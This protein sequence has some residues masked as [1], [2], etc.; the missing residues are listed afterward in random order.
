[1]TFGRN[2]QKTLDRIDIPQ[3]PNRYPI[4]NNQYRYRDVGIPFLPNTDYWM[5]QI[6]FVQRLHLRECNQ[7]SIIK[8]EKWGKMSFH[9]SDLLQ[10]NWIKLNF[11]NSGKFPPR[12]KKFPG[13]WPCN[14]DRNMHA[15]CR[16]GF[17]CSGSCWHISGFL[18]CVYW[19]LGAHFHVTKMLNYE[20]KQNTL[21]RIPKSDFRAPLAFIRKSRGKVN[22]WVFP[23]LFH[24]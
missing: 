17:N 2:I 24:F 15:D 7:N 8:F 16:G 13:R 18:L 9:D 4:F 6:Q 20:H 14:R 19:Q 1:M 10:I 23:L 21:I 11:R 12:I 3:K 5:P 22:F